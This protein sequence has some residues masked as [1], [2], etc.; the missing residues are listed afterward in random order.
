MDLYERTRAIKRFVNSDTK[1][2]EECVN[3]EIKAIFK[4]KGINAYSNDESV[5][6]SAL[7]TFNREYGTITIVD[8][9]KKP[10]D[11]CEKIDKKADI[12]IV[13]EDNRFIVC[14]MDIKV[15]GQ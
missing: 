8:L 14:G 5:L 10:I 2:L 15:N 4:A 6:K 12:T 1:I 11:R 3:N 7:D 9:F 13:I